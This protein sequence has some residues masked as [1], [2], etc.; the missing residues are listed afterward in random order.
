MRK[1]LV[2]LAVMFGTATGSFAQV[3]YST[4]TATVTDPNGNPYA[5]AAL[6]ANLV[7]SAG[8]PVSSASTPNG[9]LFNAKQVQA[10]LDATGHFSI[11]LVPNNI[12]SNPS[13][14]RWAISIS[15]PTSTQIL[16]YQPPW[17]VNYSLSVTVPI[18]LSAQISALTQPINFLNLI[19][20]Q[21]TLGGGSG[22]AGTW[23]SITGGTQTG[24]GTRQVNTFPGTVAA[25]ASRIGKVIQLPGGVQSAGT[26]AS[27][28]LTYGANATYVLPP[29]YSETI[30]STIALSQND[31]MIDC[32]PGSVLINGT[33]SS[34]VMVIT[35]TNDTIGAGCKLD[36]NNVPIY[37]YGQATLDLQGS[38]NTVL[39]GVTVVNCYSIN[40]MPSCVSAI[41]INGGKFNG[42]NLGGT[43]S[44]G[45]EIVAAGG[46][47]NPGNGVSQNF[48]V[49]GGNMGTLAIVVLPISG[50]GST[51]GV[52]KN[53][54][55]ADVN[56]RAVGGDATCGNVG[57]YSGSAGLGS[58]LNGTVMGT[59]CT[60]SG[61][62]S[63]TVSNVVISGSG[64]T[65]TITLTLGVATPFWAKEYV[66][67]SGFSTFTCLNGKD[68]PTTSTSG[69][70]VSFSTNGTT[71]TTGSGAD[72]GI[73][74]AAIFGGWSNVAGDGFI[75]S[76]NTVQLAPGT[77][78]YIQYAAYEMSC[79]NCTVTH[80]VF[81]TP[82]A[83][84]QTYGCIISYAENAIISD[85]ICN[86][87]G[88][89][90][91][92][93]G[94]VGGI[95]LTRASD[96]VQILNN[97]II[98]A[99]AD[100]TDA[101]SGGIGFGCHTS[102]GSTQRGKISGNH[103]YGPFAR[104][105]DIGDS[106]SD[107]TCPVE[108]S[109]SD[110]QIYGAKTGYE[111]YTA[112]GSVS[113]TFFSG[114]T[115]PFHTSSFTPE[116]I[117][118]NTP[119]SLP[120]GS[121]AVTQMVT[122]A[123]NN[124]ATDAFVAG[125]ISGQTNVL[126]FPYG[127]AN[128]PQTAPPYSPAAWYPASSTCSTTG[129]TPTT[130]IDASGNGNTLT[131]TGAT[132]QM[133]V[134]NGK[135]ALRLAGSGTGYQ[136]PFGTAFTAGTTIIT[137]YKKTVGASGFLVDDYVSAATNSIYF[138]PSTSINARYNSI[139][140]SSTVADDNA[141][142]VA[143]YT[144]SST[145]IGTLYLDGVQVA[146]GA[147]GT[148][149]GYLNGITVG[150]RQDRNSP[151]NGDILDTLA[152]GSALTATQLQS[153]SQYATS[154]YGLVLPGTWSIVNGVARFA[155]EYVGGNPVV[156][157][158]AGGTGAQYCSA[159]QVWTTPAA[160]IP[161]R[162]GTWSISAATSAA[163]IFATPMSAAPTSCSVPPSAS[164]AA[165]GQ[166]FPTSPLTTGFTVNVPVSGTIAGTYSCT[167]N[168]A[169]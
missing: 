50:T 47:G 141:V 126:P 104:G 23:F 77:S 146:T 9:Q 128:G 76:G 98:N 56:L 39:N 14:T 112:T 66:T 45:M 134:Y 29:D 4:V 62:A 124:L 169:N 154:Q 122:D 92:G 153:F 33:A 16:T 160:A 74:K 132:C 57:I 61:T 138:N 80:N 75:F 102:S 43:S 2:L 19:T 164:S 143:A 121:T 26:L 24:S 99:A 68:L 70:S 25:P 129:T 81:E 21:N 163:V 136:G 166:P 49:I 137:I 120:S 152:Y 110:N 28:L 125:W 150:A 109:A 10:T 114:V 157:C 101:G 106:S 3:S 127:I 130:L 27:F 105:M 55:V 48:E 113:N 15:Y 22:G 1:I 6:T 156:A 118:S 151:W 52:I 161:V 40:A 82:D 38:T 63:P 87:F 13:G 90:A 64:S 7:N 60:I 72:T 73:A 78:Q 144:I 31:V 86:G 69:T 12:L 139:S 83:Y 97:A 117:T 147:Q 96:D 53:F 162:A 32:K 44:A 142:H 115:T 8:Y 54:R 165:T 148:A 116:T 30:T 123:S 159:S 71:C 79:T 35:G 93:I 155:S 131:G 95:V 108:F 34:A 119:Q 94:L 91:R 18:D 107:H 140:L 5:N 135:P 59:T 167:S 88:A 158:P 168:N 41:N 103:I 36:N 111:I 37:N 84:A 67:L 89:H 145:G 100:N 85:N 58:V 20:G 11:Q 51:D 17:A 46:S 133:N 42:M 65:G 149:A